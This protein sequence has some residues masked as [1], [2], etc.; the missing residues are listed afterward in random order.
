MA[1]ETKENKMRLRNVPGA[2]EDIA[3]HELAINEPQEFKGK[4]NTVF[5]NDNPIQLEIGM[6]KGMFLTTL[7]EKNPN[8]NYIGIEMYG[9]TKSLAMDLKLPFLI[10]KNIKK[11]QKIIRDFKYHK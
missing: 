7:A 11:C 10:L 5:G 4:W 3:A 6:G 9:F 1:T 2:R 8:I